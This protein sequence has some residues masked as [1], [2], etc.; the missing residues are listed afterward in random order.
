MTRRSWISTPARSRA[1]S[2]SRQRGFYQP[3]DRPRTWRSRSA[4]ASWARTTGSPNTLCRGK[5]SSS[6]VKRA[7][8]VLVWLPGSAQTGSASLWLFDG[9]VVLHANVGVLHTWGDVGDHTVTTWVFRNDA[10]VSP[11]LTAIG[12]VFGEGSAAPQFQVGLRAGLI[13]DRLHLDAS[14]GG[15]TRR[16]SPGRVHPRLGVDATAILVILTLVHRPPVM[17]PIPLAPE[18]EPLLERRD[19]PALR[20]ALRDWPAPEVADVLERLDTADRA[21]LFHALPREQQAEVFA[22]LEPHERDALLR[23]LTDEDT[24]H[25]LAGLPP[26]DRAALLDELPGRVTQRLLNLLSPGDLKEVRTLLGYPEESIGRL[27]TPDYVAVRAHWTVEQALRHVRRRGRDSETINRVYVVD[28]D[29]HLIDD[30]AL[31]KLILAEPDQAV[32]DVM[33]HQFV[34]VSASEDRERAVGAIRRYDLVALPVVDSDGVLV[35]I[36]T[37]DDLLDVAEAEATED[38]HKFGSLQ[39]AVLSPLHATVGLLYRKRIG[40]LFALVFINVFSGAAIASFEETIEAVVSLVFFLPL[41]ID[42]GGNAG[43]QSAT[44]MVRALTTGDVRMADWAPLIG[45]EMAVA[46]LLGA[47]M[48]A[49]VAAVASFRAPEIIVVVALTMVSIVL[50]GSLIGMS[51]PF[52]LTRFGLDPATASAPLI[53]SLAD[54]SGVVIYFSIATWYLGLG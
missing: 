25:L 41:L 12:E 2:V 1:G 18:I 40:W 11:Y 39:D 28:R 30:I 33:D 27:M 38:F 10:V 21:L 35:G 9:D 15:H 49:G 6:M 53:T 47:T 5:R 13:P 24:R 52:L 7:A 26:D 16:A 3:A 8:S 54:I 34:S 20:E 17:E 36:V 23:A 29:W 19:W 14:Y 51:L 37:V 42:S 45:K 32:E 50:V 4:W 44:L 22:H 46:L 43:S 48:A 31:R